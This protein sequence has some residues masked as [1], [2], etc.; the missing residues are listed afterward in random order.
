[1]FFS[2]L[3]DIESSSYPPKRKKKKKRKENLDFSKIH[4]SAYH[5]TSDNQYY[6]HG[7]RS[8]LPRTKRE[9][10]PDFLDIIRVKECVFYRIC[11]LLLGVWV[12]TGSTGRKGLT[13]ET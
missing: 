1:M 7:L 4:L 13:A 3:M 6:N 12:K 5:V 9:R 2:V 11:L 10:S 8:Y